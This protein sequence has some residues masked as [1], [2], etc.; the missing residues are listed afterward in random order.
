MIISVSVVVAFQNEIRDKVVGFGSHIQLTANDENNPISLENEFLADLKNVPGVKSAHPFAL[1][2]VIL[3]SRANS[4]SA[5]VFGVIC[6]G[7]NAQYDWDFIRENL[8]S[9]RLLDFNKEREILLSKYIADKLHL[10]LHDELDIY[11]L[12]EDKDNGSKRKFELVGIY[13]S[14]LEDYDKEFA[15]ISLSEVQKLR[16]WGIGSR[17]DVED[18]LAH[19]RISLRIYPS[20]GNRNYRHDWGQGWDIRDYMTILPFK[21]TTFQ[22]IT[23][24]FSILPPGAGKQAA[25]LS[26][27]DTAW[28]DLKISGVNQ[29]K[30]LP[31]VAFQVD[32]IS[33]SIRKVYW[34]GQEIEITI[35]NSG[36]SSKF[37]ATGYEINVGEW[38]Q[39]E[40]ITQ[41]VKESTG[42]IGN[43]GYK[44]MS[45]RE[46]RDDIFSWL[47]MLDMNVII[48]ITLTVL[49][50]IIN[51]SA[52]L[53]VMILER[54]NAIGIFKAMGYSNWTIQKIF[55]YQAL[56]L[57]LRGLLWGNI[58]GIGFCIL[59]KQFGL[60]P[61]NQS[62]YYLSQVPVELNFWYIFLLNVGTAL[63]CLLALLLPSILI[64]R[65]QAVKAIKFD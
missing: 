10:K 45:I 25:P 52:A 65:I 23:T 9:G 20:G 41:E 47:E 30:S 26:V 49:V 58:I 60:I 39:L 28:L 38:N 1:L 33:D 16:Q 54:T 50:A 53:L 7:V 12:K 31:E 43:N 18:T 64:S 5:D 15:F 62:T 8:K 14:G 27:P 51:M 32:Y 17:L 61:L 13:E 24:D 3:Q 34:N 46:L 37:Y 56:Y 29:I 59:Q 2:P 22:V 19:G 36:G 11:Y 4:D 6:K 55:L 42:S 57:I 63:I 44:V 48:I 35:R 40:K 21:D